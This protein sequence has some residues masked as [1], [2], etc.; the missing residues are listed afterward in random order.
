MNFEVARAAIYARLST[1]MSDSYSTV[2]VRYENRL[3]VD[4][5][6]LETIF[7][8]CEIAWSDGVQA[9]LGSTPLVRYS[10]AVYLAVWEKEG[11]GTSQALGIL[12]ALAASFKLA[13]FGGVNTHAPRPLPGQDQL[14]WYVLGLRIPFW[15]DQA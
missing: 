2:P 4:F 12:D 13:Q 8:A 7:V 10:G 6:T 9:S 11:A 14:G 15:V 3:T 5:D 1:L